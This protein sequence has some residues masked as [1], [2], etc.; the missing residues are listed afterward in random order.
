MHLSWTH[1]GKG[2]LLLAEGVTI[3]YGRVPRDE[4]LDKVRLVESVPAA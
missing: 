3:P 1:P 4:V 2:L